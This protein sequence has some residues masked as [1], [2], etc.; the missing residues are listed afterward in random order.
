MCIVYVKKLSPLLD[1][2]I[3]IPLPLCGLTQNLKILLPFRRHNYFW[4][5]HL[6]SIWRLLILI[7]WEVKV[8]FYLLQI[9]NS[10]SSQYNWKSICGIFA[11]SQLRLFV[12]VC[13]WNFLFHC[14]I[15]LS[16][17]LYNALLITLYIWDKCSILQLW[18]WWDQQLWLSFDFFPLFSL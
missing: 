6:W 4:N 7:V 1:V 17:L 2:G 13:F 9:S 16:L 12:Q 8:Q 3:T 15:F 11:I 18:V 10:Q 5:L 14:S